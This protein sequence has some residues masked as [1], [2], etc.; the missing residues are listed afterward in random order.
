MYK[1]FRLSVILAVLTIFGCADNAPQPPVCRTSASVSIEGSAAACIIRTQ[2]TLLFIT[3]RLSGKLD[4]PGGGRT[5]DSSLACTAHRE[6]WEETG[7]N[8]E[9][10]PVL[11]TTA[12]GMVLFYCAESANLAALPSEFAAP[13]WAAVEVAG[14]QKTSPFELRHEQLRFADDLVPLRDAFVQAGKLQASL[15]EDAR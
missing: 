14:L 6:T 5:D 3:H 4:V 2:N 12:N 1:N 13:G 7:L 9:V 8:V 15:P 10:G 11:G